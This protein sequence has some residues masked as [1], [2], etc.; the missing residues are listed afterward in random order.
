[1]LRVARDAVTWLRPGGTLVLAHHRI[2]FFDFAQHAAGIQDRFL[3]QSGH[4]WAARAVR[5]TG[6]WIVCSARRR[7]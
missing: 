2:D 6:K 7:D 5:R 4:R 1:M 3:A